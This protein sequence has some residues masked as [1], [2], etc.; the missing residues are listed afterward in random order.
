MTNLQMTVRR[1]RSQSSALVGQNWTQSRFRAT[2]RSDSAV[3]S[4]LF[5]SFS[6]KVSTALKA[7]FI[8]LQ[9]IHILQFMLR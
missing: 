2:R 4:L 3:T 5:R 8:Q 1:R 9:Q 6:S 7:V